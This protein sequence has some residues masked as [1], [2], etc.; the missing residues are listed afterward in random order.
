MDH[1]IKEGSKNTFVHLL[2]F[3]NSFC[4]YL[5]IVQT[6]DLKKVRTKQK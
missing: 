1:E 4:H 6:Y 3:K 5:K 2:E